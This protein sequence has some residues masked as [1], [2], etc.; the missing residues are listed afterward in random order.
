M[1]VAGLWR[2]DEDVVTRRRRPVL[3][4]TVVAGLVMAL[5]G[6]N[7]SDPAADSTTTVDV[8]VPTPTAASA[9]AASATTTTPNPGMSADEIAVR[10]LIDQEAVE[11]AAALD[12]PDPNRPGL[13]ALNTGDARTRIVAAL[14]ERQKKGQFSRR[15][16][17][18]PVP[19]KTDAVD[20]ENADTAIVFECTI[21]DRV[22]RNSAGDVIDDSVES[23]IQ[24]TTVV[25][26][27][28]GAW[29][30]ARREVKNSVPTRN[31]CPHVR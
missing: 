30:V 16:G 31:L 13:L 14:T 25:R 1:V 9:A 15:E 8:A 21:D 6:C 22:L 11:W 17:G 18:G 7:G 19:H 20:F 29:R 4:G 12:P 27:A 3:V 5:A 10:N 24:R 26:E 2:G 28:D 23:S